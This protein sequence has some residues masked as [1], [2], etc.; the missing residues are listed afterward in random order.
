MVD[1]VL[2][3]VVGEIILVLGFVGQIMERGEGWIEGRIDVLLVLEGLAV[4]TV[5]VTV[6]PMLVALTVKGHVR[7][8]LADYRMVLGAKVKS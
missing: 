7:V 4:S 6:V 5:L 2:G 8:H 3:L 1:V